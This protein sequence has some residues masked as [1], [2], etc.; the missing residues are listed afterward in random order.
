ELSGDELRRL[1]D[2]VTD[3]IAEHID[4]LP[5]QL[6]SDV[7]GADE[8]ARSVMEPL[9]EN[10]QAIEP[11]LDDL[12]NDLIPKSFNT[13]GPGYFAFIPGGGILHAAAADLIA[14]AVNRYVTVHAAAPA[15]AQL[16][17]T[18][19][20]W[21][22]DVFGCPAGSGGFLTSGGSLANWS[23]LVAA[24]VN[25]LP[26]NFLAGVIYASDQAHH[27]VQKAAAMAGFPRDAVRVI[28]SDNRFRI[29]L[30]LLKRRI[31]RDRAK[32][33]TPFALVANGGTVHTGAVDDLDALADL[34]EQE[35]MWLH[36]DA[37]YG[38]FFLL[39]ERGKHALRGIERADSVTLDPH[40]GLF[41]P[42]GTGAMIV[43]DG[44]TLRPA[45]SASGDYLPAMQ[46]D[47]DLVDFCD[48]SP[49]LSR[50]FRGLRV[51]LPMKVHGAGTFRR[52]LDEKLDLAR[53]AAE[54]LRTIEG[55]EIVAEPELSIVAFRLVREGLGD[56][57]LDCLNQALLA[58]INA[59][60]RVFLTPT[61]LDGRLVIRLAVLSFRSH[62]DRVSAC[63]EIIR[64]A[65]NE[66][67]R[68][69]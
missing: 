42:Y 35:G 7:E 41:L 69:P 59:D 12:F 36:V 63:L 17:A 27:S 40:T 48:V 64:A 34:A 28:P 43:R 18:V 65:V 20:R 44:S 58:R 49:E 39:T 2:A 24:R 29:R 8:I 3:R 53:W 68:T 55:V 66:T 15:L 6:A 33:K 5:D 45:F 56:D 19:V 16:E 13:A 23:A 47:P 46:E 4:T 9:P 54:Q 25:R 57:E 37:A 62:L 50:D 32:G 51:W 38:G 1:I 67:T 26:E 52:C 30:D 14:N 61:R 10:G 22:R 11:L 60:G 21:F 31:E